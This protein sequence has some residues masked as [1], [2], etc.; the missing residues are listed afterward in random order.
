MVQHP[1]ARK[2]TAETLAS[3]IRPPAPM[4][5]SEWIARNVVL[6]D[7][8]SAGQLWSAAGAPYLVEIADCLSEEHPS[9]LVTVRKSQQTGASILALAWALYVADRE[10]GNMLYGVPGIDALKD[11]SSGK[12]QPLIDAFQKRARRKVILPQTLRSG[13]GST[14]YEK[15]F[16]KG[17]RLWLANANS[18]MDLSSKTA[19]KGVKDEVSKWTDIPGYGDPETLYFGRFTA[20]RRTQDYKI[21]EVSTPEVDT[22]DE[23]GEADGH[24]RVD[25]SFRRSDQRYWHFACPKCGSVQ[26]HR[27]EQFRPNDTDP[28]ASVYECEGCGHGISE[29]ERV[30]MLRPENGAQW[31]ATAPGVGRH[32][33][34]HIDAFVSLMMS[35]GAIAEDYVKS[36]TSAVGQK[37]FS[38][39]V[40]GLPYQHK[41]DAPDHQRLMDRR[42]AHLQRGV[43]PPDALLLTAGVD[44]QMR[45]VY[46]EIVGWGR[47]RRSWVI[48]TLYIDGDTDA[49]DGSV[50]SRLRDEVL[51]RRFADAWGR[52]RIVDLVAIDSGYR[53]NVVYSWVRL[54]QAMHPET[55]R[56][57]LLAVKGLEGWGRPVLG[58]PSPVDIHYGGERIRK[59]VSLYGVGTWPLKSSVY[60]DLR[61]MRTG[62]ASEPPPPGYCHFGGWLDEVYFRQLCSESLQDTLVRGRKTGTKWVPHGENHYFDCRVYNL[63]MAEHLGLSS[64]T[65]DDWAVLQ[66]L[67]GQPP[68]DENLFTAAPVAPQDPDTSP[69]AA[70]PRSGWFA[71]RL[72]RSR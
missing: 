67:R 48:D 45:G 31:I 34:F 61:K 72:N 2:L 9:N 29:A 18:V 39:L 37:D 38:N 21:L 63:A 12:L 55:G 69:D 4:R 49:H 14:T 1:S 33:G 28:Q 3:G 50:F 41:G 58:T 40:L 17:G 6:V 10:P 16:A 22:G 7:G 62:E 25:R 32:P 24:C 54:N 35:Y 44:V 68:A 11:L 23:L 52:E 46:A 36:R 51:A 26:Y 13:A 43:V 57:R 19:K 8:P 5:V 66:R 53:S 42:E 70:P 59:G 15:V 65:A 56:D 47:D 30:I 20:H 64:M 27:F 71:H 60:L